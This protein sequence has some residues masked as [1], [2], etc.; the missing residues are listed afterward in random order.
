[1]HDKR[2]D[3]VLCCLIS[4]HTYFL[5]IF[6]VASLKVF[7]EKSYIEL[8]SNIHMNVRILNLGTIDENRTGRTQLLEM[9]IND[10]SMT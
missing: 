6:S 7:Q 9:A 3:C 10:L 2:S 4:F 8:Q 1:M 5:F